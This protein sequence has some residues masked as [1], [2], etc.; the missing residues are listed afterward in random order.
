MILPVHIDI[1]HPVLGK[2]IEIPYRHHE[3]W[4]GTGYLRG[5]AG[6]EI[7]LPARIFVV[8][9]VWDALSN[10]RPYNKAWSRERIIQYYEE[11]SGR[12]CGPVIAKRF[13]SMVDKGGI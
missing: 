12:H 7:P 1:T 3:K 11:Q 4:D 5:L 2:A 8:A 9:D 10:D 13:L 6:E